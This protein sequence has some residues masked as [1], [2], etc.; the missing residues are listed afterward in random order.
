MLEG[1]MIKIN[2]NP[3]FFGKNMNRRWFKVGFVPGPGSEKKLVIS[4]STSKTAKDPRGWLYVEDVSGIYCR[5][6]VSC[7]RLVAWPRSISLKT[8]TLLEDISWA[9]DMYPPPS[10]SKELHRLTGS[11]DQDHDRDRERDRDREHDQDYDRD[12]HQDVGRERDRDRHQDRDRERYRNRDR[13]RE[14]VAAVRGMIMTLGNAALRPQ[15]IADRDVKSGNIR[16]SEHDVSDDSQEEDEDSPRPSTNSS[17]RSVLVAQI[18][19]GSGLEG[20]MAQCKNVMSDSEEE[21]VNYENKQADPP[22]ESPREPLTSSTDPI[23]DDFSH[24]KLEQMIPQRMNLTEP[25]KHKNSEYFDSDE[26]EQEQPPSKTNT[27]LSDN[28]TPVSNVTADNNF[29]HDDWDAEE[30]P[31]SQPTTKAAYSTALTGGVAADANF[32]H[33]DWDD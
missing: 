4:Y 13:P 22:E 25:T 18:K 28:K 6:V 14:P 29:V 3:S 27:R 1:W 12:R 15:R 20:G 2:S 31:T 7:L 26:E 5:R 24:E 19:S 32:V 16:P 33:D 10:D 8:K 30:E 11:H 23:D 21:D 9:C 17:T